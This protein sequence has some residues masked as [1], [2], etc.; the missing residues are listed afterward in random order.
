MNI[1]LLLT[2]KN[3]PFQY[4]SKVIPIFVLPLMALC[5]SNTTR[6]IRHGLA[7]QSTTSNDPVEV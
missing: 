5:I 1:K 2:N 6:A 7:K 4:D 3:S